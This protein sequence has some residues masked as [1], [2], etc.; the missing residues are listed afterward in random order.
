MFCHRSLNNETSK[1]LFE[2]TLPAQDWVPT[3]ADFS[4]I[5]VYNRELSDGSADLPV[6]EE[7][8]DRL[9]LGITSTENGS[10]EHGRFVELRNH[11][12]KVNP[13]L[14]TA[15]NSPNHAESESPSP[16]PGLTTSTSEA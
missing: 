2:A 14:H 9:T 3:P 13:D 12:L 1:I 4:K 8:Y 7:Q 6:K 10:G 5:C 16:S 11:L 15:L